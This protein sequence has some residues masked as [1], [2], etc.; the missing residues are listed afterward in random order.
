M[1]CVALAGLGG[2]S[3]F[4]RA[5]SDAIGGDAKSGVIATPNAPGGGMAVSREAGSIEAV[6]KITRE[7]RGMDAT[8]REAWMAV[9]APFTDAAAFREVGV[10]PAKALLFYGPPG[11]GKTTLARKVAEEAG[12]KFISSTGSALLGGYIGQGSGHVKKLFEEAR[13][14]PDG[15]AIIFIDEIDGLG[16]RTA[17]GNMGQFA[18]SAINE[19]L[20]FLDGMAADENVRVI[21]ATN[22]PAAL[23]EALVRA[24]RFDRKIY[25]GMP[26]EEVLG[27]ILAQSLSQLPVSRSLNRTALAERLKGYGPAD[28]KAVVET[29]G[30]RALER[31]LLDEAS[32]AETAQTSVVMRRVATPPEDLVSFLSDDNYLLWNPKT[33]SFHLSEDGSGVSEP[34]WMSAAMDAMTERVKSLPEEERNAL[35]DP[36]EALIDEDTGRSAWMWSEGEGQLPQFLWNSL[37]DE[38]A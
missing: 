37:S 32:A 35:L 21:G 11:G 14:A 9:G 34:V 18:A 10:K 15:K 22:N 7:L 12:V 28:I 26:S 6:A 17:E 23:D 31:V 13:K 30:R 1:V 16:S 33:E 27:E 38:Q 8:V 29:A 24:G 5:A 4:G 20:S 19:L 36:A 3:A 2:F 25:I